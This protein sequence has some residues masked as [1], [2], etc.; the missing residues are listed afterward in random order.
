MTQPNIDDGECTCYKQFA[1]IT[2]NYCNLQQSEKIILENDEL[3]ATNDML[4][5]ENTFH[6]KSLG[7]L[8][9][10]ILSHGELSRS[11]VSEIIGI[12]QK[13]I[14]EFLKKNNCN[15]ELEK[16]MKKVEKDWEK[17]YASKM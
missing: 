13:K 3:K 1:G 7:R 9:S 5:K 8:I 4:E 17:N 14:I 15:T 16:H 6:I 2:C 10:F 12:N 11:K